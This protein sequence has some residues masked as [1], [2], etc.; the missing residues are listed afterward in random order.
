MREG[1]WGSHQ[2]EA[3]ALKW[4]TSDGLTEVY[5]DEGD[6]ALL[7]LLWRRPCIIGEERDVLTAGVRDVGDGRAGR[8][9][10][11][12]AAGALD[13]AIVMCQSSSLRSGASLEEEVGR[14]MP[15]RPH[16]SSRRR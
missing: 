7:P 16:M 14:K 10:R 3:R 1:P 6:V 4:A 8:S 11:K 12:R 5:L 15:R 9:C 13:G 2:E